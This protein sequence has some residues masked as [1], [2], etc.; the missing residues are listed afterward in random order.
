M[1]EQASDRVRVVF[2]DRS[3]AAGDVLIGADCIHSTVRQLI[4]P[5]SPRPPTPA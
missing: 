5:P 4:D 2:D 1:A 3:E